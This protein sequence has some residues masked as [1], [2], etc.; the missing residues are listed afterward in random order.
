MSR[1]VVCLFVLCLLSGVNGHGWMTEPTPRDPQTT[2]TNMPC[3]ANSTPDSKTTVISGQSFT[4]SWITPH[5]FTS[6]IL[7]SYAP[8]S[9]S[10]AEDAFTQFAQSTYPQGSVQATLPSGLSPGVYTIQ[11]NQVDQGY[12]NCADITLV[13]SDA[14][15]GSTSGSSDVYVFSDGSGEI[16]AQTGVV[17]CFNGYTLNKSSNTCKKNGGGISGGQAFGIF[18]LVIVIVGI[19][20]C[21]AGVIFLKVKRPEKY[22]EYKM[23]LGDKGRSLVDKVKNLKS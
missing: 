11:F 10:T 21:V 18:L 3:E 20:G 17:T 13:P 9:E 7:I 19:I 12:Y 22:D 4:V 15:P 1:I 8:A 16:N 2:N 23:K 6:Q 5:Q 14:T